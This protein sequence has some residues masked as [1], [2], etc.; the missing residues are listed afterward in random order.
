M[1]SSESFG[2]RLLVMTKFCANELG[3][4]SSPWAAGSLETTMLNAKE[5]LEHGQ[6]GLE[7]RSEVDITGPMEQLEFQGTGLLTEKESRRKRNSAKL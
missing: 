7:D 6:T 4:T 1:S 5:K 2:G 3:S